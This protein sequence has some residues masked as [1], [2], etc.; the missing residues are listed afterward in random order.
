MLD[1]KAPDDAALL[2][3]ILRDA[4]VFIQNL[5]AGAAERAGFGS[6]EPC[7]HV[8]RAWSRAT[9]RVTAKTDRMRR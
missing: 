9:S 8:I 1:I 4:D 3:R 7:A 5:A 2:H 6:A